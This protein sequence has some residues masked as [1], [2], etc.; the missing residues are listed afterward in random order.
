MSAP[1]SFPG[2]VSS[3][4]CSRFSHSLFGASASKGAQHDMRRALFLRG[5]CHSVYGPGTALPSILRR[6]GDGQPECRWIYHRLF[7]GAWCPGLL[8]H[9]ARFGGSATE[10]SQADIGKQLGN[11]KD[12]LLESRDIRFL[13]LR[14]LCR[15]R[16]GVRS[17]LYRRRLRAVHRCGT[18]DFATRGHGSLAA[19]RPK[20][21]G[22]QLSESVGAT[23][24]RDPLPVLRCSLTRLEAGECDTSSMGL[25][26][27]AGPS[28]AGFFSRVKMC[29]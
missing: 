18:G 2:F 11:G 1:A 15:R 6:L 13:A 16:A 25:A 23:S 17:N 24:A 4:S 12:I 29:C 9:R 8:R 10:I 26:A 19:K 5:D 7:T 21:S 22:S 20:L 14:P 3:C 27:L 28:A